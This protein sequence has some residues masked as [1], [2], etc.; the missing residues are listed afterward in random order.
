L[1]AGWFAGNRGNGK[2]VDGLDELDEL[3]GF[4]LDG[5]GFELDGFELD[6]FGL[7][8]CFV[9]MLDPLFSGSPDTRSKEAR[10]G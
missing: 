1:F 10:R 8:L 2:P 4:E 6:G 3:A 5:D 7:G 9:L